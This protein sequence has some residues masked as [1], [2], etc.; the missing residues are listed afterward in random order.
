MKNENRNTIR[1]TLALLLA[2]TQP[3]AASFAHADADRAGNGGD[4]DEMEFT[5]LAYE[6]VDLLEIL[7]GRHELRQPIDV[8]GL[9]NRLHNLQI[10]FVR[11]PQSPKATSPRPGPPYTPCRGDV[12]SPT[13][14]FV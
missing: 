6:V 5:G 8:A 2:T 11:E 1:A 7:Q 13:Q 9:K 3:L 14:D 4:F 12:F 10:R